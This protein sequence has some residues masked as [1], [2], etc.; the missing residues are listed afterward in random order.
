MPSV[1]N[2]PGRFLTSCRDTEVVILTMIVMLMVILLSPPNPLPHLASFHFAGL[3]ATNII[4]YL[5]HVHPLHNVISTAYGRYTH[6]HTHT[7]TF[8][9]PFPSPSGSPHSAKYPAAR[10][11]GTAIRCLISSLSLIASVVKIGYCCVPGI[12][13]TAWHPECERDYTNLFAEILL[14]LSATA[15][16]PIYISNTNP[17]SRRSPIVSH[18]IPLLLRFLPAFLVLLLPFV[19]FSPPLCLVSPPYPS[20]LSIKLCVKLAPSLTLSPTV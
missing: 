19:L 17:R 4:L 8:P 12:Y 5:F 9:S 6:T 14:P 10:V 13:C 16:A 20:N 11:L 2:N 15:S 7:S 3:S 18:L 1:R